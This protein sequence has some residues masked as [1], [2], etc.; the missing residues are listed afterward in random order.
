MLTSG[1]PWLQGLFVRTCSMQ[2]RA[3]IEYSCRHVHTYTCAHSL[4]HTQTSTG[5]SLAARA[6]VFAASGCPLAYLWPP[7][8][9]AEPYLGAAHGLVGI[10]YVLLLLQRHAPQCWPDQQQDMADVRAALRYVWVLVVVSMGLAGDAAA[11]FVRAILRAVH[12]P[13]VH[14]KLFVFALRRPSTHQHSTHQPTTTQPHSY[15]L[16]CEVDAP[17]RPAGSGGHYPTL[18]RL[19]GY[20]NNDSSSRTLVHWCHG[21]PGAV[22]LW[23]TA[24]EVGVW[25]LVCG[26]AG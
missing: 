3:C 17:G 5:R 24:H 13:A 4:C 20:D 18:M 2:L 21:A 23:C 15:V 6:P 14:L 1:D 10:L 16:S 22:Y 8:P 19:Q 26:E 25:V 12:E 7:G 11:A 9:S